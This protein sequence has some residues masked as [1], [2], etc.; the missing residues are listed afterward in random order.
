[1]F[2]NWRHL[3][4]FEHVTDGLSQTLLIGEKFVHAEF[5]GDTVSG[6]GTFWNSDLQTA[7]GEWGALH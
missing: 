6:D 1:M 4:G 3:L 5:Q 2:K 7:K